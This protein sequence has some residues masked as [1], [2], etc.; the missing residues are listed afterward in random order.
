MYDVDRTALGATVRCQACPATLTVDSDHGPTIERS[1]KAF[2]RR[3]HCRQTTIP[4][5]GGHRH[6][7]QNHHRD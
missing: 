6:G 1:I 4:E 7:E 5:T 2:E 3:H